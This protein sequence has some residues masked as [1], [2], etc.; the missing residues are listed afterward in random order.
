MNIAV[1][2]WSHEVPPRH[3]GGIERVCHMLCKGLVKQGHTV[4]L[5]SSPASLGYNGLTF[6]YANP[7]PSCIDRIYRR[8]VFESKSAFLAFK[9]DLIYS[10]RFWPESFSLAN[11]LKKPFIY[12]QH[13]TSHRSDLSRVLAANSRF[14]FLQGISD[15]Q[16]SSIDMDSKSNRVFRVYNAVD[17]DVIKP[18]LSPS[19]DYLVYLGRLNYD[20]GVDIAV[21]ISLKSG[22]PL[23]IAGVLRRD[24]SD[25]YSLFREKVKPFLGKHIKFI[26]PITDEDKSNL[27]GNALALL[28]P[29]RWREPFGIVMAE[30]LAAGT[31]VLGTPLGS[32]PEVI[33]HGQTG[34]LFGSVDECVE[35]LSDIHS[36]SRMDCRRRALSMFSEASFMRD[37]NS[38]FDRILSLSL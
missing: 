19:S 16:I 14:G 17:C 15:D 4:H 27:L 29:N 31:P 20:K 25:A 36:I 22:I 18:V 23:I 6:G 1:F 38:M 34:H 3:Y 13:N 5:L 24:E 21:E 7:S 33:S 32:I 8:V 35:I 9:S 37:I 30:A 2:T 28:V 10:F 26:G 12:S 11:Q